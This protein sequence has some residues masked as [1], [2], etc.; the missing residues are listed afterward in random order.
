MQA[1][2]LPFLSQNY[3]GL[4]NKLHNHSIPKFNS[5]GTE[6]CQPHE[7]GREPQVS[8]EIAA[9][10]VTLISARGDREQRT[11]LICDWT[12]DPWKLR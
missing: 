9:Q 8:G 12:P 10:D 1:L 6:F 3:S 5:Q 4:G 11:Q 7:L 2:K